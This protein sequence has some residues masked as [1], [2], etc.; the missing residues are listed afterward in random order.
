MFV[1][2]VDT[3]V[4][5]AQ[6]A[7]MTNAGQCCVAGSRTFV[8]DTIYDEFVKKT[9]AKAA[10]RTVGDPYE[11]STVQG[12]QVACFL[13]STLWKNYSPRSPG[14]WLALLALMK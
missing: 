4:A 6:E 9:V 10:T 2:S 13:C 11:K 3:A 5:A 1:H 12:P 8:Q 7:V 14:T